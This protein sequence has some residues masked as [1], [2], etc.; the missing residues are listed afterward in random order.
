MGSL[1][2]WVGVFELIFFVIQRKG[3]IYIYIDCFYGTYMCI[4]KVV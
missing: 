1:M 4:P 2:G 3:Y